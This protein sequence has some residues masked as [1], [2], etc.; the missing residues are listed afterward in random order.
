MWCKEEQLEDGSN[1]SDVI[2][3]KRENTKYLPNQKFPDGIVAVPDLVKAAENADVLIFVLPHQY[4][5]QAC[6]DLVGKIKP[7][8]FAMTLIKVINN[9]Y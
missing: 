5:R 8:S 1:L 6:D 4:T 7:T 9:R 3:E 2:N